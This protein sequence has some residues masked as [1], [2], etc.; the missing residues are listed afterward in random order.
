MPLTS[1][2]SEFK[3]PH[4]PQLRW[5]PFLSRFAGEDEH[6]ALAVHRPIIRVMVRV[7]QRAQF[8]QVF[9]GAVVLG[10]LGGAMDA[11][12]VDAVDQHARQ[13]LGVHARMLACGQVDEGRPLRSLAPG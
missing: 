5:V 8:R 11:R 13:G 6:D 3:L 9:R 10:A 12:V 7:L 4:L 2:W 1:S